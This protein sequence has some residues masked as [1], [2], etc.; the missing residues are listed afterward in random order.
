MAIFHHGVAELELAPRRRNGSVSSMLTSTHTR[1]TRPQADRRTHTLLPLLSLA[2]LL[3]PLCRSAAAELRVMTFNIW[4]G[5]E[6][7]GQPLERT[8]EVIRVAKADVVGLQET[9]G[10]ERN[11]QRPDQG[12]KLAAILGWH[13]LSQ[14]GSPGILSRFPIGEPTPARHGVQIRLPSGKRIWLFNVHLMHAPYQPYQLLRIPYA[15][16]PF[17]QTAD[18]LVAAARAARGQQVEQLLAEL[19]PALAT[20]EPVFLTGDFNEPSHLDWTQRAVTARLAPL[21]VRY[22]ST[23]SVMAAGMRDAFR[24]AHPNETARPGWTW[25]PITRP[26]DPKDRHDR[27]D[28][29]FVAGAGVTVRQCQVAGEAAPA[30]DLVIAPYPSDHRAV[31]ATVSVP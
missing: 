7:G 29:V 23:A 6:S 13:Y 20:G 17:L 24:E 9:R 27:I 10:E 30:A 16:A 12:Q 2:L 26:D 19:R 18:E 5:G 15:G 11:G 1:P 8:A 14:G 28:F 21:V 4:V 22:P 3:S 25:T 31:V